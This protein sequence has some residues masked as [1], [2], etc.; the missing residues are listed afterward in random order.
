MCVCVC[1]HVYV[2][3]CMCAC[4]CVRVYVCVCMCVC[5]R[6]CMYVCVLGNCEEIQKGS[7]RECEVVIVG[8]CTRDQQRKLKRLRGGYCVCTM[9]HELQ[10]GCLWTLY[11]TPKLTNQIDEVSTFF[12]WS[13]LINQM[14]FPK[15]VILFGQF[16]S[17]ILHSPT[18]DVKSHKRS[19]MEAE[20]IFY[21]GNV[22]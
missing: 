20:E 8:N 10:V 11:W 4:V 3:V 18:T 1:V 16:Q 21:F 19:R 7:W 13:I 6:A 9:Y 12:D 5:V 14:R 17:S 2:C 22:V 15:P